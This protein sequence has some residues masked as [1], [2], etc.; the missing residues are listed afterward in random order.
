M[1]SLALKIVIGAALAAGFAATTQKG[2]KLVTDMSSR[3]AVT[4][5]S[6]SRIDGFRKLKADTV[7]AGNAWRSA[8]SRVAALALEIKKADKPTKEM[9][10]NFEAAKREAA[11]AK[12]TFN[13]QSQ[14]LQTLRND[15]SAAGQSTRG[16]ATQNR[17]LARTYDRLNAQ[18]VRLSMLTSARDKNLERRSELRGKMVG[19]AVMVATVAAPVKLAIDFE[20]SMADVKKVVNFDKGELG[21]S[22][23]K[24]MRADI[25]AMSTQLPM[26]ASGITEIIAQAGRAGIARDELKGFAQDAIRMS[27][28]FDMSAQESGSA[29]TGMRSIFGLNQKDVVKLGDSINYLDNNMDATAAGI[30]RVSDRTGS[31]AKLFGLTGQQNAALASTFLALKTPPQV[32]S[33][34]MNAMM[35]KMAAADKQGEKFQQGLAAIG[36]TATDL[37]SAIEDDAQGALVSFLEDVNDAD[38]KIGLLTE[39]FGLEYAD[40]IAK[41]SGGIGLYKKALGLAGDEQAY[42]NSMNKEY[43]ARAA[44][45]ANNTVIFRNRLNRL[46]VNLGTVLLP[47]VNL[48]LGALGA[49]TDVLAMATARFPL[50]TTVIVGGIAA[51]VALRVITLANGY[52]MTFLKGAWLSAKIQ[53]VTLRGWVIASNLSMRSLNVTALVTAGRFRLLAAG[54]LIQAFAGSLMTLARLAIPMVI[55]GMR[56]LTVA[57]LFNPIGLAITGLVLGAALIMK[58]WKPISGFFKNLWS[59]VAGPAL[60][61]MTVMKTIF[62]WSPLAVLRAGIGA[63]AR[64]LGGVFKSPLNMARGLWNGFKLLMSWSPM[65]LIVRGWSVLPNIYKGIFDKVKNIAKLAMDGLKSFLMAPIKLVEGLWNKLKGLGSK[66]KAAAVQVIQ[67]LK[68][69]LKAGAM[70]VGALAAPSVAMAAP[71]AIA[72]QTSAPAAVSVA[73][74][75][76]IPAAP[77]AI[78]AQTFAPAAAV[79]LPSPSIIPAAPVAIAPQTFAPAA[80]V[81]LPAPEVIAPQSV[82]D[83]TPE[84]IAPSTFDA[85]A[86]PDA[87]PNKTEITVVRVGVEPSDSGPRPPIPPPAPP[88]H[89]PMR[90]GDIHLHLSMENVFGDVGSLVQQLRPALER[91]LK[92]AQEANLHD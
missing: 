81:S 30:L 78:A 76:I 55:T 88:K 77:V 17:D 73:E 4:Q 33:T 65:G 20:S 46:A 68:P 34:A 27:I 89:P 32:A 83:S 50:L 59:K 14:S 3:I 62:S 22:Q 19:A 66:S 28:A 51:L 21:Q 12:S 8:Q 6:L 40:D 16:L 70:T 23:F 63:G 15:M 52:A 54:G 7:Q 41:L 31:M 90:A 38:D 64:W 35:L 53:L 85:S 11:A 67:P 13:R 79:S 29:M 74:P 36:W 60:A 2:G 26:A 57:M 75:S 71:V 5:Q 10:R 47:A 1:K 49:V 82:I 72:P 48:T 84:F 39:L 92:E 80:A 87:V 91:M 25:M 43:E 37:K 24:E 61:T 58:F 86:A 9:T 45:S 69:A 18:Q 56:A 42:L 44:T